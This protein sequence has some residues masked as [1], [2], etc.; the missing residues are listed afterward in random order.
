MRRGGLGRRGLALAA[1]ALLALAACRAERT[2]SGSGP[3]AL[4]GGCASPAPLQGTPDPRTPAYIVV[5]KEGVDAAAETQRLATALGFTPTF[6][7][8]S[9]P[10]FAAA[11]GDSAL[12]AVRCAASVRYVEHD[13]PAS[14]AR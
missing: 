3:A 11:L 7:Y 9:L 1:T 14:I 12:R 4:R 10:G 5:Y 6:V 8:A 13:Q 2:E